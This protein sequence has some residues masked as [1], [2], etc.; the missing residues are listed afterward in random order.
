[1]RRSWQIRLVIATSFKF[2]T[3]ACTFHQEKQN[4]HR[5]YIPELAIDKH[6]LM[7]QIRTII[8]TSFKFN[9]AACTYHQEKWNC[10]RKYI[11]TN[12]SDR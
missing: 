3:T 12:A 5:K 11:P 1:V 6:R 4:Y 10:H 2:N 9:S 8:A 7:E